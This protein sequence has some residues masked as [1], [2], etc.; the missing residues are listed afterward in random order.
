[1]RYAAVLLATAASQA[2]YN[3]LTK[4]PKPCACK[5]NE[6]GVDAVPFVLVAALVVPTVVVMIII[7]CCTCW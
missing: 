7:Q 6:R 5:S 4:G 2:H 3:Q 1:V